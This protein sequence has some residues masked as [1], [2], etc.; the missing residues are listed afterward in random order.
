MNDTAPQ[1]ESSPQEPAT[2]RPRRIIAL[3]LLV[4]GAVG[5]LV[6][7]A[8]EDFWKVYPEIV[9][10]LLAGEFLTGEEGFAIASICMLPAT[11][12]SPPA[13]F[14]WLEQSRLLTWLLRVCTCFVAGVL[15]YFLIDEPPSG[16][17]LP[18]LS[19]SATLSFAGLCLIRHSRPVEPGVS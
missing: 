9:Q 18:F 5:F 11:L 12:V 16:R 13:L 19:T 15:W 8:I 14:L 3:T 4:A 2:P 6:S 17:L 10:M 1:A 7:L